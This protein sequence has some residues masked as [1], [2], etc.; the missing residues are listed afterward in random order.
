MPEVYP[1]MLP[2]DTLLWRRF[3]KEWGDYFERFEYDLHVGRGVTIKEP[4]PQEI[5]R[6]ATILTQKRI[7]AVGYFRDE[8]WIFEVKPDAGLS[9]LGQ[10][11]GYKALW[12]RDR[13]LPKKLILAIVTDYLNEDMQFLMRHYGIRIYE[14][15]KILSDREKDLY[16][17]YGPA[18]LEMGIL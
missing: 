14:V 12:I 13:G 5:M 7:D 1:H 16:D 4:M 3:L 10:L 18:S 6:A 17:R 9:A 11:L 2:Y 8:T 15:Y